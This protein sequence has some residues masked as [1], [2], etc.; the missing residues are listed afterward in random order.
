MAPVSI[1]YERRLRALPFVTALQQVYSPRWAAAF[2]IR[3]IH[4]LTYGP[5]DRA[6]GSNSSL[7]QPL[8]HVAPGRTARR[9]SAGP[10]AGAGTGALAR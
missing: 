8:M 7:K 5:D 6:P 9:L 3:D 2:A 4:R 10:C 1:R